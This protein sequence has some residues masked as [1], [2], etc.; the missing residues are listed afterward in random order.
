[1]VV[2]DQ[3]T[4]SITNEIHSQFGPAPIHDNSHTLTVPYCFQSAE[5]YTLCV[6]IVVL[7]GWVQIKRGSDQLL[8]TFLEMLEMCARVLHT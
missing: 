8:N 5:L 6:G 1:M 7:M 4:C 2:I 3:G